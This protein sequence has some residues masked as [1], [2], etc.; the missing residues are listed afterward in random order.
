MMKIWLLKPMQLVAGTSKQSTER[1]EE[2]EALLL[3]RMF[4]KTS[5]CFTAVRLLLFES[6]GYKPLE[7]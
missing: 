5:S 7:T 2:E 6:K 3:Y 4:P 1:V